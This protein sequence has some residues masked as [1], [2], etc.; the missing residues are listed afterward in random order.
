MVNNRAGAAPAVN[1]R[2]DSI[3][4]VNSQADIARAF[5][6]LQWHYFK[7]ALRHPVP[8]IEKS[9]S[10][11]LFP[12]SRRCDSRDSD[13]LTH[14]PQSWFYDP[15]VGIASNGANIGRQRQQLLP[16]SHARL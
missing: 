9:V 15:F 6:C 13:R 2:C 16:L 5:T 8:R 14:A 11:N 10:T 7:A 4:G 1:S 3:D 12:F